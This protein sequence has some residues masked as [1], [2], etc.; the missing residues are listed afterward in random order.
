MSNQNISTILALSMM[1]SPI[2]LHTEQAAY[3]KPAIPVVASHRSSLRKL[4][5]QLA[6][7]PRLQAMGSYVGELQERW[8][9]P[10]DHL[11]IGMTIGDLSFAS[12]NVL[13][14]AYMRWVIENSQGL[15]RSMIMDEHIYIGESELSVR[16]QHTIRLVLQ[17]LS[18]D[19]SILS[20][21]ECSAP[22]L[23]ELKA[24]LPDRY[25]IIEH[26]GEATIIDLN[27]FQILSAK[28]VT[29]VFAEDPKRGFQELILRCLDNDQKFR[30]I[31]AHIPGDPAKPA[32]F[33]FA[34]YLASTFDPGITTIALGDMNFNELEMADAMTQAFQD[35]NP[36]AIYSPYCTNISPYSF[37]S[38]AIDHFIVYSPD[39]TSKVTFNLPEQLLDGL[40]P[41]VAL[42]N[43]NFRTVPIF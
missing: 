12:W 13:D 41:I 37:I 15:S 20:L 32:R 29:G 40:T 5:Q 34:K 18:N 4:S 6:L 19:R 39:Q 42:L 9:F 31:N 10:S 28:Q 16:D 24:Q 38:K 3:E 27:R 30:I 2:V 25:K 1:T 36:F 26:Y 7:P 33:E 17:M 8:Q 43:P 22:F 35:E 11:P 23:T 21:Q 14:S